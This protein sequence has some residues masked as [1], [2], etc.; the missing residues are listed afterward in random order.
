MFTINVASNKSKSTSSDDISS[1]S[2]MSMSPA[3]SYL[4]P[5]KCPSPKPVNIVFGT[6][7]HVDP[8]AHLQK[9]EDGEIEDK[10]KPFCLPPS[11]TLLHPSPTYTPKEFS[12][13]HNSREVE[14]LNKAADNASDNA[15]AASTVSRIVRVGGSPTFSSQPLATLYQSLRTIYRT[16]PPE[17]TTEKDTEAKPTS[18]FNDS[19][20][21]ND[22]DEDSWSAWRPASPTPPQGDST[23]PPSQWA[24]GEHPGMGWDLNDPFTTTFYRIQIPDPTTNRVIVAPYI[25]YS[26]QRNRAEVQGT[27]GKGYPIITRPLEPIPVDYYCPPITPE[28]MILLDAK[29]PFANV[30]NKILN[31]KFP[32]VISAAVRRYQYYQEEKYATQ[33]KIRRLQEKENE[34][35]EKAMCV[36]S[37]LENTNILGRLACFED[38][39]YHDL[40]HDQIAAYEF[41][42]VIHTYRGVITTSALDAT[43]NPY[44]KHFITH[45]DSPLTF[46]PRNSDSPRAVPFTIP[47][48]GCLDRHCSKERNHDE[49]EDYFQENADVIEERLHQR[50]HKRKP[51]PKHPLSAHKQ[52]FKCGH[53]G[54]IRAMCY[55]NHRPVVFPRRK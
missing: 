43:P 51:L 52:C 16:P 40:T 42:K 1:M 21:D 41:L 46:R 47:L 53:M 48:R 2:S 23:H 49:V 26:V 18:K 10:D 13:S 3:L 24:C 45:L 15:D 29:A 50:L 22:D 5:V 39:V 33:I 9:F 28:Q 14:A 55:N 54:H 38:E 20:D 11:L 44:R 17:S 31:D 6:A 30:V 12:N 35:L 7:E 25:S 37:D 19:D 36:L 27:Y 4:T 32:L 8:L 34:C